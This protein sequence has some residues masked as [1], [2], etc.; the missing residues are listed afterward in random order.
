MIL[1]WHKTVNL[2]SFITNSA[3]CLQLLLNPSKSGQQMVALS[4][5]GQTQ[6]MVYTEKVIHTILFYYPLNFFIFSLSSSDFD[7]ISPLCFISIFFLL[8]LF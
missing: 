2:L 4:V 8:K 6:Q 5:A 7:F 3:E 1:K